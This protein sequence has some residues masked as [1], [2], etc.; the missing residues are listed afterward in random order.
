MKSPEPQYAGFSSK[1]KCSSNPLFCSRNKAALALSLCA[2]YMPQSNAYDFSPGYGVDGSFNASLGYSAMRRVEGI[3]T[4]GLHPNHDDGDRNFDKGIVSSIAKASY[5]LSLQKDT[6][7]GSVGL[8]HR[9]LAFY[10]FKIRDSHNDNASPNTLN[11]NPIFGGSLTDLNDFTEDTQDQVGSDFRVL[12]LFVYYNSTS[13]EHPVSVRLG[14]QL[15]NWGENAFIQTGISNAIN[16]AD[17]SQANIPGTEVKEILLPVESLYGSV[18]L[19]PALSLEGYYQTEWKPTI[20]PPVGTYLSTNDYIAENGGESI[21]LPG[22]A[23]YRRGGDIDVDDDGQWGLALRWF[24]ESLGE[25]D[26][27]FYYLNYHSKLPSLSLAG[28]P[29][30]PGG[31]Q[32]AVGPGTYHVTYFEDVKLYGVSFN[33]VLWDTA[34]SGEVAYHD[35][36]PL[37]TIQVNGAAIGQAASMGGDPL[38]LF[39]PEDLVVAQL[40]LNRSLNNDAFIGDLADNVGLIVEFGVVH[41]PELEDGEI[42]KSSDLRDQ[43]AWGYKARMEFTYYDAFGRYISALSGTDLVATV[44]F[45]HDVEGHSA[46]VAG[47]FED[48]AKSAGFGLRAQWQNTLET[49]IRYNAFFGDSDLSD[50][51]NVSLSFKYRY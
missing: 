45:N 3:D 26:F 29:F 39:T 14:Q 51:D 22:G 10:D 34:F 25:T 23:T 2:V 17:V 36:A 11:G 19:T 31:A 16:P 46:I 27:G 6:E 1:G 32:P 40:T 48:N 13:D 37:Q 7:N 42:F 41:S 43:T 9:G 30:G 44:V 5:E 33:T 8:F 50:R 24:A 4:D 20:A 21:I 49:E 38:Y 12:D 18:E 47:S 35:G 15:V 28:S